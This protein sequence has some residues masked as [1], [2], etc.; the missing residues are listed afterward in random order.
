MRSSVLHELDILQA[1]GDGEQVAKRDLL[2]RIGIA[3]RL[4]DR[5]LKQLVAKGLLKVKTAPTRRMLY[6]L[7]PKGFAEKARLSYEFITYAYRM[8]RE[9]HRLASNMLNDLATR[10]GVRRVVFYGAE[11][12]AEVA[13]VS[14]PENNIELAGVADEEHV[15]ETCAGQRVVSID[16]LDTLQFDRI[17][18]TKFSK[19]DD[20]ILLKLLET[21]GAVVNLFEPEAPGGEGS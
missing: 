21:R 17:I 10:E 8:N 2:H 16:A 11:P 7:T 5:T 4:A 13:A 1:I 15:G 3:G 18:F 14:L 9:C 20:V 12:M 19:R 6:W